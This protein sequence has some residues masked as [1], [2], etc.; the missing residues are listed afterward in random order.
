[1]NTQ[2]LV[3]VVDDDAAVSA[4]LCLLIETLGVRAR[5]Y[6]S[7]RLFLDDP[8][9]KDCACLVLDVRMPGM[10]GLELQTRLAESGWIAP[11]IFITGHGDVPMAVQ[12]IRGGAIDFLQKPFNDQAL[13]DRVQ[14]ALERYGAMREEHGR[15]AELQARFA[16]LT[17]RE[18]EVLQHVVQGRMNKTI[19]DQLGISIKTVE[20]HRASIMRKMRACSLADLVQMAVEAKR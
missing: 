2:H 14:Q 20:D 1:M 15:R 4:S 12:A 3:C 11:I 7:A 17:P 13:L 19:A 9:H 6:P 16:L 8:C 18:Q 5:A 10:S